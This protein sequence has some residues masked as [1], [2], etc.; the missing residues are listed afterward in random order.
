MTEKL[1]TKQYRFFNTQVNRIMNRVQK[2]SLP[3]FE[4]VPI[5]DVILFFFKGFQKGALVTR[6]SAIAFN[7]IIALLPSTIFFFTLIPF[8][9]FPNFQSELLELFKNILP[10]NAYSLMEATLVDVITQK[11]HGLLFFMFLATIIFSTNGVHA[12]ISAFNVSL[13]TFDTHSWIAQRLVSLVFVF[14]LVSLLG[15]ATILILFSKMAINYLAEL[16]LFER[17]ITYIL[18]ALGKWLIILALIFFAISFLYYLSPAKRSKWKFF[19]AGSTLATIL[20]ILSSLGFSSFV[21]NFGQFNKLYGSIGTLIVILL[22]L[23]IN[24]ISLLIGFELN[25]SIRTANSEKEKL[26]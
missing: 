3:G 18:I 15:T 26:K 13:H 25:V 6:A 12:L 14:I 9:P 23:Y 19:S 21:N 24:S 22:W 1:E 17:N 7:L 10:E 20:F 5:Y 16:E 8:L 4:K 2:V 11:S